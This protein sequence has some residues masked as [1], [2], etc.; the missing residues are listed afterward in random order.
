VLNL[1]AAHDRPRLSCS[2]RVLW[3]PESGL[4]FTPHASVSVPSVLCRDRDA[5]TRARARHALHPQPRARRAGVMKEVPAGADIRLVLADKS[6]LVGQALDELPRVPVYATV[7]EVA[8]GVAGEAMLEINYMVRSAALCQLVIVLAVLRVRCRPGLQLPE[9]PACK[10][11]SGAAAVRGTSAKPSPSLPRL[12]RGAARPQVLYANNGPYTMLGRP[13]GEH[14]GDWEHVTARCTRATGRLVS[15]YYGAHRH[16]DGTWVGA[17]DVPVEPRTGR[18]VAYAALNGHGHY[19]AAKTHKRAFGLAN[20]RTS[21]AGPVWA[22][23]R[24]ITVTRPLGGVH[25]PAD[26]PSQAPHEQRVPLVATRGGKAF[27]AVESGEAG[28]RAELKW[29]KSPPEGLKGDDGKAPGTIGGG[30]VAPADVTAEFTPWLEA[31]ARARAAAVLSD[32]ALDSFSCSGVSLVHMCRIVCKI[33]QCRM[34]VANVCA[35]L[36]CMCA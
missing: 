8:A 3:G 29:P 31:R 2:S 34:R 21:A 26:L 25:T 18:I 11:R 9:Q 23:A 6:A 7:K 36:L 16:G 24:C 19:P 27:P 15:V 12:T 30:P 1:R 20:D 28:M 5:H 4:Q 22:P 17:R 13:T 35:T 10:S 14:E 32:A 33:A